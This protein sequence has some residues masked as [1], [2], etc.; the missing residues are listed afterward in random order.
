MIWICFMT[1][2][3]TNCSTKRMHRVLIMIN[4]LITSNAGTIKQRNHLTHIQWKKKQ[5]H[6]SQR[7]L[8]GFYCKQ[9][10]RRCEILPTL[11][12]EAE[13]KCHKAAKDTTLTQ[14]S[15]WGDWTRRDTITPV[16]W[17]TSWHVCYNCKRQMTENKWPCSDAAQCTWW[18]TVVVFF[19]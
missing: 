1:I 7:R 12:C 5:D 6:W 19:L 18:W 15:V 16:E 2:L 11:V 10:E 13:N 8:T 14:S 4:L 17:C 3:P 9:K